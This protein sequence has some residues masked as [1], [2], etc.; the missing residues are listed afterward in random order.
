MH[1][2]GDRMRPPDSPP[3]SPVKTPFRQTANRWLDVPPTTYHCF[4]VW[5]LS[6]IT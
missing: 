2:Y 6:A 3:A 1:N 4:H 5:T